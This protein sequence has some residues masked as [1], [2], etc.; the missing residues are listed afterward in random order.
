MFK[1]FS[2]HFIAAPS[3]GSIYFAQLLAASLSNTLHDELCWLF[4]SQES[5]KKLQHQQQNPRINK[6]TDQ[7]SGP[8]G[9][10]H[11][12]L[13]YKWSRIS[14]DGLLATAC[15]LFLCQTA[16]PNGQTAMA[17]NEK[18]TILLWTLHGEMD[19]LSFM[20]VCKYV[21]ACLWHAYTRHTQTNVTSLIRAF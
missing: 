2:V 1:C 9:I 5:D 15:W 19:H 21:W 16:H 20:C 8:R 12:I 3:P 18:A 11:R 7:N 17:H 6:N 4:S 14:F 13:F 10:R